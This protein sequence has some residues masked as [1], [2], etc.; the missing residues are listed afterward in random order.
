MFIVVLPQPLEVNTQVSVKSATPSFYQSS[1]PDI[2]LRRGDDKCSCAWLLGLI[3][4]LPL[5][6]YCCA[7]YEIHQPYGTDFKRNVIF[8]V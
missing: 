8:K 5:N 2:V 3:R 6:Q 4:T 7:V 1:L